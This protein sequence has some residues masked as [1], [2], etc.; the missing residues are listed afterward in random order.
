[1]IRQVGTIHVFLR[2][3]T[4][5]TMSTT[6]HCFLRCAAFLFAAS[7]I[8]F[9]ESSN[10]QSPVKD[11]QSLVGNDIRHSSVEAHLRFL[12]SDLLRGRDTP[13]PEQEIAGAYIESHFMRYGVQP[14]WPDGYRQ[15][16]E[17]MNVIPADEGRM[18]LD[19]LELSSPEQFLQLSGG[20]VDLQ[21][22]AVFVDFGAEDDFKKSKVEGKIVV[23]RAGQK[24]MTGAREMFIESREK[25]RRAE[26]AGAIGLIE[27]Y[28]S[29]QVSWTIL[30]FY[31]NTP[32]MSLSNGKEASAFPV[33]WLD[34]TGNDKL[35]KLS[36][37]KGNARVETKGAVREETHAYNVVGWVEGTDP[38]LKNE[39]VVYSAHYDHVGIGAPDAE[40]DS[41]YNGTRDNAIGTVTV[42][43]AAASI[44]RNPL[45]RSAIFALFTGEEKGLLGSE[46][47]VKHPPVPLSQVVFNFNSDN[48]G[49]ND[50]TVAT[51]VGLSRT[52]A[53]SHIASACN[54]YGI[55]A[56]NDPVPRQN[57]FDRSDQ[58]NFAR[59]GVP[60]VMYSLGLT[61][62]DDEI[63]KYYHRPGDTPDSVDYGYLFK[64]T[65]AYVLA[66]RKI[67]NADIRPL[68][69]EGDK[70]FEAGK[71]LYGH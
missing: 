68:W 3:S 66:A 71:T 9:P 52:S 5:H 39:Y 38:E 41:I 32:R 44:A 31:L 27:L 57:L 4:H 2:P 50:T 56:I 61:A 40:G 37:I 69:Q 43:E 28:S 54:T 46:W 48:A 8:G 36:K 13:S 1:M 17:L 70:Y 53:E 65:Q 22:K 18:T 6:F 21:G 64:F 63:M 62:F 30:Q 47:F 24:G 58:A 49:Y 34:D 20:D 19:G 10:A 11:D 51:V 67:G 35:A 26:E 55:E 59:E 25:A 12:A 42:L 14:M 29:P 23:A 16:V 7:I 60:A 15:R 45:R 33:F